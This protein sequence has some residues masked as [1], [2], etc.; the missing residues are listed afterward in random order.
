MKK[1]V[2]DELIEKLELRISSM[3]KDNKHH[4]TVR[5]VLQEA[6]NE[7]EKLKETHKQ[8]I[9]EAYESGCEEVEENG[10]ALYDLKA[11]DYYNKT[12][13]Q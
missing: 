4:V 1:S 13:N 9:I 12:F 3:N 10:I 6:I 11:E 2:I 7:A 5:A 8:E